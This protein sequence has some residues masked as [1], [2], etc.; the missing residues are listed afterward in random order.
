MSTIKINKSQNFSRKKYIE[1]TIRKIFDI[2]LK[3]NDF[4]Y[5]ILNE[6]NGFQTI[7]Y[8]KNKKLHQL[9]LKSKKGRNMKF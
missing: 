1:V 4:N 3:S 8:L 9:F 2:K 6:L 7:Y 5:I